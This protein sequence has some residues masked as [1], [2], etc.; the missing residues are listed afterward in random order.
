MKKIAAILFL[1]ISG[2]ANAT[3]PTVTNVT[4]TITTGQTLTITGTYMV[5]EDNT[6]WL[7]T[8][9]DVNFKSSAYGF[10]G[11]SNTLDNYCDAGY[12]Y[13]SYDTNVKLMGSKSN[14]WNITGSG[15]FDSVEDTFGCSTNQYYWRAY[16]RYHSTSGGTWPDGSTWKL[17]IQTGTDPL[18]GAFW[19]ISPNNGSAPT[20]VHITNTQ[21]GGGNSTQEF[22]LPA[23][24]EF[25]VWYAIEGRYDN[26]GNTTSI[27]WNGN[28]LGSYALISGTHP[29]IFY[30]GFPTA[31]ST[32]S[33]GL[34]LNIDN[35]ALSTTRVYPSTKVE[36]SG[37]NGSTWTYQNPVS[38]GTNAA[39][40]DTAITVKAN[41]PTLT[42]SNYLMRVTNNK[43]ESSS[44]YTMGAAASSGSLRSGVSASGVTFR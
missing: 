22:S 32:P 21:T 29:G 5:D 12:C 37:D 17:F 25:D 11:T 15:H 4:G 36:I 27:Y 14:K 24:M 44:N 1:L 33:F 40:S 41:L 34:D 39:I 42:A 43:Q 28:L 20:A 9:T 31:D 30:M 26:V 16:V 13:G 19:S 7:T 35:L 2:I 10:E 3:T 23:T 8:G 6:N 18:S 38:V